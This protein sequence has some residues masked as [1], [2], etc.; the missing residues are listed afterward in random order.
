VTLPFGFDA[1]WPGLGRTSGLSVAKSI[2]QHE[3][4]TR[5]DVWPGLDEADLERFGEPELLRGVRSGG[6][7]SLIHSVV[8]GFH[9]WRIWHPCFPV[10]LQVAISPEIHF[11]AQLA[12]KLGTLEEAGTA[13]AKLPQPNEFSSVEAA[14]RENR[15]DL[16]G[17]T[18]TWLNPTELWLIEG[19]HRLIGMASLHQQKV[20]ITAPATFTVFVGRP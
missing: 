1:A 20:A 9:D 18:A 6:R 14:W 5:P 4:K 10:I 13:A 12:S 19:C 8:R 2:L 17:L 16:S 15:V 3:R 7:G 11:R